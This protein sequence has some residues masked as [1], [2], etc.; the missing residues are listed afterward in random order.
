M[1]GPTGEAP[2]RVGRGGCGGRGL[3]TV[4]VV[5]D[6]P[7]LGALVVRVLR[8]DGYPVAQARHGAEALRLAR[9]E[10][11]ACVLLDLDLPDMDGAAF[12]AAFRAAGGAA[13]AVPIV[14][15]TGLDARAAARETERLGA[16]GFLTKP[17]DLDALTALVGRFAGRTYSPG[18]S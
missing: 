5:E 13:G 3:D 7:V 6:D 8:E 4:L 9:Q 10:H 11:P 18:T 2:L 14:L 1:L 15:C 16:V 12:V 17:Y